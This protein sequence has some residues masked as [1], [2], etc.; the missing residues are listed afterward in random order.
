SGLM[1]RLQRLHR[2]YFGPVAYKTDADH[3]PGVRDVLDAYEIA[4][5]E[6]KP[7]NGG[8]GLAFGGRQASDLAGDGI[9]AENTGRMR[10]VKRLAVFLHGDAVCPG[11]A[12]LGDEGGQNAGFHI[13]AEDRAR[14]RVAG[15]HIAIR[16]D[17][18]VVELLRVS[19]GE[20]GDFH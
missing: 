13:Q 18:D 3:A 11:R 14:G 20:G 10:Y 12:A 15:I 16:R 9:N 19:G 8:D 7:V 6:I 2:L 4:L 1:V 17:G 5:P